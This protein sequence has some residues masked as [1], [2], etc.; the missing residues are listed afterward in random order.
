VISLDKHPF[1][2][3]YMKTMLHLT[4]IK[5]DKRPLGTWCGFA[6]NQEPAL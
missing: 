2:V 3:Y 6:Y 4:T 1:D 5:A